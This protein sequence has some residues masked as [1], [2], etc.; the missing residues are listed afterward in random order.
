MLTP[1]PCPRWSAET[2]SSILAFRDRLAFVRRRT[3]NVAHSSPIVSSFG[4]MCRF[5]RLSR[6]SGVFRSVGNRYASGLTFNNKVL[7]TAISIAVPGERATFLA[8]RRPI[9]LTCRS[10]EGG[11]R[12]KGHDTVAQR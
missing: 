6:L 4:R 12:I 11:C 9:R 2:L 8:V 10:E 1:R 5:Q 7:Q 3:G